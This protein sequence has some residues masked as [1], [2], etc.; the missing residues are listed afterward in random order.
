MRGIATL[1]GVSPPLQAHAVRGGAAPLTD[2][3]LIT[4]L[5][6]ILIGRKVLLFLLHSLLAVVWEF[7][8]G[9]T[10]GTCCPDLWRKEKG[11]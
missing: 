4:V 5:S 6:Y 7:A 3:S 9:I 11:E 10:E 2:C 1:G 8:A